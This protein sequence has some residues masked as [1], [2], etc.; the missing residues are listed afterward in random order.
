MK[1]FWAAIC[2]W[3]LVVCPGPWAWGADNEFTR[4]SLQNIHALSVLV[5]TLRPEIA[6]QGLTRSIIRADV[7][8]ALRQDGFTVL[9]PAD[10]LRQPE[11]PYLY[12]NVNV[13]QHDVYVYSVTVELHQNVHLVRDPAVLTDAATWSKR[14]IGVSGVLD[15]IRSHTLD[16]V[17]IFLNAHESVNPAAGSEKNSSRDHDGSRL[18][19]EFPQTE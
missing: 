9:P 10:G 16:M 19:P 18:Q 12:V 4:P 13:F 15:E 6:K 1:L 11:K 14:Y 17:R 5:E 7:E 2:I 3:C 8:A